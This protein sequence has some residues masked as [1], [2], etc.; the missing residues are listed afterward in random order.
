MAEEE[1]KFFFYFIFKLYNIVLVLLNM[2]KKIKNLNGI[3]QFHFWYRP[4]G[5]ENRIWKRYLYP[6]VTA[7][8]F[9]T[10]KIMKQ[11]K[12]LSTGQWMKETWHIYTKQ[13]CCHE[14]EENPAICDTFVN[15]LAQYVSSAKKP[16]FKLVKSERKWSC[17]V[18]SDSLQPPGL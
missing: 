7:A 11:L 9:T 4:K 14:K 6:H 5:D 2:K 17:S 16:W 8:V 15:Y 1:K 18:V 3:Q 10:A 13:C 12:C